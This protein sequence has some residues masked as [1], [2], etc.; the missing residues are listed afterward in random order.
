MGCSG[1]LSAH[2]TGHIIAL[3]TCGAGE[4]VVANTSCL[5]VND[6]AWNLC[7]VLEAIEIISINASATSKHV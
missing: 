6:S 7:T 4:G 2:V 3:H 1:D 5:T